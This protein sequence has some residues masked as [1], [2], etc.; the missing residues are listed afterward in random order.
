MPRR[1]LNNFGEQRLAL[2]QR[3]A[4]RSSFSVIEFEFHIAYPRKAQEQAFENIR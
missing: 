1:V 3:F 4:D 2:G